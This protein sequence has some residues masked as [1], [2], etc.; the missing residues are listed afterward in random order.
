MNTNNTA[1]KPDVQISPTWPNS[2]ILSGDR[3]DA[4]ASRPY[5]HRVV[6]ASEQTETVRS[7]PIA[8]E[9]SQWQTQMLLFLA[10]HPLLS[11]LFR[12]PF[13]Y[14]HS[15]YIP[16]Y[17]SNLLN[18]T[19]HVVRLPSYYRRQRRCARIRPPLHTTSSACL[20]VN[21]V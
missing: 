9:N 5:C 10:C 19:N 17:H 18:S 15:F 8:L 6:T 4:A 12:L 14:Q 21:L 7:P 3:V 11:K 1:Q 2:Q 16:K 13:I 20:P